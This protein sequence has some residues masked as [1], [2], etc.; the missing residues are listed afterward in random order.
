MTLE[1]LY[2]L[3]SFGIDLSGMMRNEET[4]DTYTENVGLGRL[5]VLVDTEQQGNSGQTYFIQLN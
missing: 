1:R 2:D 3:N 5:C 4:T